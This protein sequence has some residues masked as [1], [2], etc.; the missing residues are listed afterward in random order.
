[1]ALSSEAAPVIPA[2]TPLISI[3]PMDALISVITWG[4]S[5]A[6]IYFVLSF[7]FKIEAI[8]KTYRNLIK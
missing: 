2:K 3:P 8:T 6:L 7:V 5:G 1:V 4:V